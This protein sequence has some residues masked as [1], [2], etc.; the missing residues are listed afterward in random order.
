MA[1]LLLFVFIVASALQRTRQKNGT[2]TKE[3]GA[4]PHRKPT[5]AQG[6]RMKMGRPVGLVANPFKTA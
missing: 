1:T 2:C 4:A 3:T 5:T 6:N